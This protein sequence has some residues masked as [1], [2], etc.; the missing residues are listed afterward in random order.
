MITPYLL[1][2]VSKMLNFTEIEYGKSQTRFFSA[3]ARKWSNTLNER[4][5]KIIH[6]DM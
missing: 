4:K 2:R 6:F 3:L 1:N 5:T